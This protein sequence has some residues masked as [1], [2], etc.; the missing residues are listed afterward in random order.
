MTRAFDYE[1]I[2]NELKNC[3]EGWVQYYDIGQV[4]AELRDYMAVDGGPIQSLDD[5]DPDDF[6]DI[7][8]CWDLT[9]DDNI[10]EA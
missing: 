2:H 1:K 4:M 7:L 5:V 6:Q 9:N 10:E 8:K 3:L